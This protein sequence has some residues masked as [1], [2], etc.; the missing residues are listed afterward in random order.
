MKIDGQE[1]NVLAR[2][3]LARTAAFLNRFRYRIAGTDECRAAAREIASAMRTYCDA[4]EEESF[5]LHPRVLWWVGKAAAIAYVA[6]SI[7]G[8]LGGYWCFL[9]AILTLLGLSYTIVAY[10]V[11]GTLFD[12]FFPGS[13]GCNVVGILEPAGRIE[14]QVLFVGH[15]D[16]PHVLG[17][18]SHV[19][20]IAFV[21]FLLGIASYLYLTASL[22]A[23]SIGQAATHT[24]QPFAGAQAWLVVIGLLFAAP[25]FFFSTNRPSPG[26]GDN[27]NACSMAMSV[28]E[29]FFKERQKGNPLKRTRVVVLSTDGE[30]VGQRGAIHHA[31]EH[32]GE[33]RRIPTRVFNVDSVYKLEDLA[34]CTRDRNFATGLCR[35]MAEELVQI[36][37]ARGV[38]LRT[39]AIPFGGGG[40]DAAAF[41]TAGIPATSVIGLPTG[42]FSRSPYYH[43]EKDTVE[44]IEPRAVEAVIGIAV[45][46]VRG[47][48]ADP[49]DVL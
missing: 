28:A 5:T 37:G 47:L 39:L 9:G 20:Q 7:L 10:V 35:P 25:L 19:P 8:L 17:F 16:S 42:L 14:Q 27:L 26:A 12:R 43:T 40:T 4:V 32:R 49:R 2:S 21:R 15:H 23:A 30:E 33:L 31:R 11:Y 38:R 46:Y 22:V 44:K 13:E 18:L 34:V 45:D 29:Y 24:Q 48:D 6:G 41:A 1:V 3:C 36:A